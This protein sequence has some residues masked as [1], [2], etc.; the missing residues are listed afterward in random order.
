MLSLKSIIII[1][2]I[3]TVNLRN[4][5]LNLLVAFDALMTER[6]VSRA[7]SRVGLSQ[8]AMSSALARLRGLVGDE[9]LM[10]RAGEMQPTPR[11][12]E[13]V[14]PVHQALGLVEK[15][16]EPAKEFE[17]RTAPRSFALAM[18]DYSA[19]IL[20]PRLIPRLEEHAPAVDLR[21]K[22]YDRSLFAE[23]LASGASD[24]A[25]SFVC[26]APSLVRS[27]VI[28]RE[29]FVC[30]V[31]ADNPAVGERLSLDTYLALNHLLVSSKGDPEGK[32]DGLLVRR[33]LR[34]RV[35]ITVPHF[36][37]VPRILPGTRL[38]ATIAERVVT[39]WKGPGLRYLEPPIEID[40]FDVHMA[41]DRRRDNDPALVWLR[42]QIFEVAK[43]V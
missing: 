21:I 25:V 42:E 12:L 29:R 17:P 14:G 16:F 32:V 41:W 31:C 33:G 35:S 43:E 10:R 7:A 28:F 23:Q 18:T 24:L 37:L 40:G 6:N 9:L 27:Q 22:P 19:S 39:R 13:L 4:F 36:L 38:I 2:S 20:L 34:R 26:N 8:S 15:A 11:A 3:D 30:V 1:S 5:D